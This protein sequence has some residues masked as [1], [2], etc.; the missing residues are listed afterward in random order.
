MQLGHGQNNDLFLRMPM[1]DTGPVF[2]CG[3]QIWIFENVVTVS[4][5]IIA[6]LEKMKINCSGTL[7]FYN[8]R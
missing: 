3:A 1:A 7:F 5:V 2:L 6:I 8:T 4:D